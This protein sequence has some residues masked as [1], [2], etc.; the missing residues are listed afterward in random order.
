LS[1]PLQIE[2]DQGWF[3]RLSMILSENRPPLFGIMLWVPKQIS[4]NAA[5][6]VQSRV[7]SGRSGHEPVTNLQ[8]STARAASFTPEKY[9]KLTA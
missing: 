4:S 2:A 9:G 5:D 1:D 3:F 8:P 7:T 6:F